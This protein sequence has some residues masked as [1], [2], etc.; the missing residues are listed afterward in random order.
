MIVFSSI[1]AELFFMA[2]DAISLVQR[3]KAQA[4]LRTI[5]GE[6]G[7][8]QM[9]RNLGILHDNVYWNVPHGRFATRKSAWNSSR[10]V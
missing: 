3:Q 6:L 9:D 4:C 10:L 8:S 2:V 1:S 5:V 7:S